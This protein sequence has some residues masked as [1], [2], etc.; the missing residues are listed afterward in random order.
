V[1]TVLDTPELAHAMT[2]HNY[3]L[4]K[5]FFSYRV[6]QQQLEG[7]LISFFGEGYGE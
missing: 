5:N 7:M 4:A 2:E 3:N 6:L 1:Q